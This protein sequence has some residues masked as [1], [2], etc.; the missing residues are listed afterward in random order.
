MSDL[1]RAQLYALTL[2]ADGKVKWGLPMQQFWTVS[3]TIPPKNATFLALL[4]QD[5][6]ATN[7]H[8]GP[9]WHRPVQVTTAGWEAL[10]VD[11]E[12]QRILPAGA[13]VTYVGVDVNLIDMF[14][15]SPAVATHDWEV[16]IDGVEHHLFEPVDLALAPG[17]NVTDT[18]GDHW[19]VIA[20]RSAP[21]LNHVTWVTDT[22]QS[23]ECRTIPTNT[24][25]IGHRIPEFDL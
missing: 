22:N 4:E 9:R 18:A 11:P 19:V 20:P 25:T 13:K 16:V 12:K 15:G 21:A 23:M 1:T 17:Q 24:L 5:L 8:P 2:V 7:I 6:I 10:G 14:T 3:V